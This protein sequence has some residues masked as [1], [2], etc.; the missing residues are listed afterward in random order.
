[1]LLSQKAVG[2]F[3]NRELEVINIYMQD[4]STEE[5]CK[6]L[7]DF[8]LDCFNEMEAEDQNMNPEVRDNLASAYQLAKKYLRDLED[9]SDS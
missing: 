5:K 3:M 7:N 1:M 4:I 9:L 8:V 6:K 2:V